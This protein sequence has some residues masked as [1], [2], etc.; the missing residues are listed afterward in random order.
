[1]KIYR[2]CFWLLTAL[3]FLSI[4]ITAFFNI[5]IS[6]LICIITGFLL[7]ILSLLLVIYHFIMIY[8]YEK[9]KKEKSKLN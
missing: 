9:D 7:I 3:V 6:A 2:I 8:K 5:Y 4:G 1:M